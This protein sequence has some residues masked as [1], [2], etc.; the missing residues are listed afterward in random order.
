MDLDDL[1]KSIREEGTGGKIVPAKFFGEDKYDKY[2]KELLSDGRIKGDNLTPDE[3][4]EGVKAYRKGKIK[5]QN[6]VDRLLDRKKRIEIQTKRTPSIDN[7]GK[8]VIR[9]TNIDVNNFKSE[10]TQENLE[11][12]LRGIDSILET[13]KRDQELEEKKAAQDKKKQE[14]E[15]RKLQEEKLEKRFEGLRK[16]S[17]KI[18]KPVKSILDRIIGFF[19][20]IIL[21]RIVFKLVEWLGDPKN[22]SKVNSIIRFLTDFGPKLLAT[23][24]VFGTG[25]GRAIR[26]LTSLLIKGAIRLGAAALLLLK[27]MG[28]RKAGGLARGLLGGRGRALATVLEVAGT[29]AAIGGISKLLEG[30]SQ[31][32]DTKEGQSPEAQAFNQGGKV[33]GPTGIDKVPAMLT[34][35]EFVMSKGAV[36]KYGVDTLKDMN[37]SGGGTNKP[38]VIQNKLYA[39]GG[40]Y[41]GEEK[42]KPP[43]KGLRPIIPQASSPVTNIFQQQGLAKGTRATAGFTGMGKPGFDAISGGAKYIQSSKPQ[44]LGRGAYSAPTSQGAMRYAGSQGSLGGPQVPGGVIRTIVPGG[45]ARIPFLEPQMKVAPEVF[46]KGRLLADKLQSG[47]RPNSALANKLRGQMT[48]GAGRLPG[49]KGGSPLQIIA[50]LALGNVLDRGVEAVGKPL[51]NALTRSILSATGKE[52]RAKQ[53]N[54]ELF[55]MTG[56]QLTPE[57]VENY[58]KNKFGDMSPALQQ[59]EAT[60]NKRH[61]ELMKST[62]PEKITAYDKEHGQGA[63][64]QKLKE[65]LYRIYGGQATG[66]TKPAA[67]TPTGQVVGRENLSPQAQA[68]IAR[69]NAKRGLPPDIQYTR[70]GKRISAE[71]FNRIPGMGGGGGGLNALTNQAKVR[72]IPGMLGS[73][74]DSFRKK[75]IDPQTILEDAKSKAMSMAT[76]MGGTVRDGNIGTPTAEE[77]K[78]IDRLNAK[79]AEADKLEAYNKMMSTQGGLR[80]N[81]EKDPLFAEY[82]KIQDDINHPLHD[83]V[84]GDLFADNKPGM[85]FAEFKK[86]KAQQKNGVD[87]VSKPAQI[88]T[89]TPSVSLPSPPVKPQ[90][91]VSVVDGG[92][93]RSQSAMESSASPS[94][95]NIPSPPKSASKSKILGIP[96]PF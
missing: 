30:D 62:N 72:S 67:P 44:I 20:K 9:K 19:T 38:K 75:K 37:A 66:Q 91:K 27:K 26:K 31:P 83:K 46:D 35:G 88:A 7:N 55:G 87:N 61:A 48:S 5:F 73:L 42:E 45:A 4:K 76:S 6:F 59:S 63:Y 92:A 49:L 69:L 56:P 65:K 39:Q 18:I 85:R 29:V 68:A 53:I 94:V 40:G 43:A 12:V 70:N 8:L 86:F 47:Y 14:N 10:G 13:L 28:L 33:E 78:A 34:A 21:G 81:L 17:E 95:P 89:T 25:V 57:M 1:L 77:Q 15:K 32:D 51:G 50:N 74:F 93:T 23:Y 90:A 22:Q 16:T 84:A 11:E 3:R 60:A 2:Y 54:P 41:L 79:R 36:Q 80:K 52:E 64:S 96:L 24:L 82:E 71:E 58:N